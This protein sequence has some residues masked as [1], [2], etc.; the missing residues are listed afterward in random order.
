[1]HRVLDHYLHTAFAAARLL[2]PYRDQITLSPAK[3]QARAVEIVTLDQA[4]AWF[5]A[6]WRVLLGAH[7]LAIAD[8]FPEHAWKL[9][10]T[11]ATFLHRS[12]YLREQA[13]A[14]TAALAAARQLGDLAAQ[15]AV[16]RDLGHA[17]LSLGAHEEAGQHL[18]EALSLLCRLGDNRG[19]ARAHIDML[20]FCTAQGRY[21]EALHH[22]E[23]G[24]RLYR[25]IGYGPGVAL[26]LNEVGWTLALD[27]R[28]QEALDRCSQAYALRGELPA[29]MVAQA[30]TLDSLGYIHSRLGHHAK[31]I[32]CYQQAIGLLSDTQSTAPRAQMLANLGDAHQA[33]GDAGAARSAW[34]EALAILDG[35]HH[36]EADRIRARLG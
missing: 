35:L 9:F 14:G 4:L 6:E 18:N 32:S 8:G 27:G 29:D 5:R 28:Y 3:P 7:S 11:M 20:G 19:E 15:A 13:A 36:P 23:E 2:N 34:E 22:G 1:V 17:Q 33:A 30:N 16:Q 21:R 26:T 12:G 10:W 31:A 25:A 24:L